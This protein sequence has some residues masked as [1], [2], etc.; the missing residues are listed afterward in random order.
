MS[1]APFGS[2]YKLHFLVRGFFFSAHEVNL[3]ANRV[4]FSF[5]LSSLHS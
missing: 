1:V 4:F 2:V 3:N 5:P